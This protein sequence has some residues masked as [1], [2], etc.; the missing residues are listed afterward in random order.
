M[1]ANK[2]YR[3][4]YLFPIQLPWNQFR[5]NTLNQINTY[6]KSETCISPF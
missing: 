3:N 4:Q 6:K 5:H 2:L 1:Y